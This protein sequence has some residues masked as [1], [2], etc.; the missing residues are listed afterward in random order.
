MARPYLIFAA[1]VAI[2]AQAGFVAPAAADPKDDERGKAML[3]DTY[4]QFSQWPKG[5]VDH[6][7]NG[8][9]GAG[10]CSTPPC[11]PPPQGAGGKSGQKRPVGKELNAWQTSKVI[12]PGILEGGNAFGRQGPAGM[13]TP[14]GARGSKGMAGAAIR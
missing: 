6:N 7:N 3:A 14:L 4:F 12:G 10:G 13:G 8:S 11:S 1:A 2:A 5:W 9:Q